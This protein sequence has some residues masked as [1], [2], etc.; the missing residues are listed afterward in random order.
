[1]GFVDIM[2]SSFVADSMRKTM[3]GQWLLQWKRPLYAYEP[4]AYKPIK[5][6]VQEPAWEKGVDFRGVLPDRHGRRYDMGSA[7]KSFRE[8]RTTLRNT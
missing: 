4:D 8:N 7:P 1:M 5:T 3:S 6:T 2:A